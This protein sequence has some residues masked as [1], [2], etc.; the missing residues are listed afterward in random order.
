MSVEEI[1]QT[2]SELVAE[3]FAMEPAEVTM[4]T[5]FEEDLGADSVDLVDLVMARYAPIYAGDRMIGGVFGGV[6]MGGKVQQCVGD[7]QIVGGQVLLKNVER[8][9]AERCGLFTFSPLRTEPGKVLQ[10]ARHMD[11]VRPEQF[12]KQAQ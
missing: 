3:Q 1:F 8:P 5:S 9:F 7:A 2:M 12:L 4:D 6:L 10:P 11:V